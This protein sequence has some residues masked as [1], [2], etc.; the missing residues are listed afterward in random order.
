MGLTEPGPG[1][2]IR[3]HIHQ[4]ERTRRNL[5]RDSRGRWC[6]LPGQP[7]KLRRPADDRPRSRRR[8]RRRSRSR[9]RRRRSRRRR[10]G[11]SERRPK[12]RRISEGHGRFR[13]RSKE[14]L[15]AKNSSQHKEVEK[16]DQI[17]EF[18]EA[19]PDFE[20]PV[21]SPTSSNE[22]QVT[23]AIPVKQE[24]PEAMQFEGD[25]A[26]HPDE[27]HT[28]KLKEGPGRSSLSSLSKEERFLCFWHN[29][30]RTR[31]NVRRL[32]NEPDRWVC[33]DE[34]P[35][36]LEGQRKP[37]PGSA[38]QTLKQKL[39]KTGTMRTRPSKGSG[40]RRGV[41]RTTAPK[42]GRFAKGQ[43]SAPARRSEALK[44]SKTSEEW[45]QCV[46]HG[47][48]RCRDLMARNVKG[49]WVCTGDDRCKGVDK[50]L[51][52]G[53]PRSPSRGIHFEAKSTQPIRTGGNLVPLG[54]QRMKEERS[55]SRGD[56][57][58]SDTET[59]E[60]LEEESTAQ[61]MKN[62][63]P[64]SAPTL[65]MRMCAVHKK[66]RH[67]ER[68]ERCGR[69]W[70]CKSSDSCRTSGPKKPERSDESH[71]CEIHN[72]VRTVQNMEKRRDGKWICKPEC[73]CLSSRNS[74]R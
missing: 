60:L 61:L 7:C 30:Y 42:L 50:G 69:G 58:G 12:R 18:M 73:R 66:L 59:M 23:Q 74:E 19:E 43:V 64:T 32:S 11:R 38:L 71:V 39:T 41:K 31:R 55:P 3:C 34:D 1:A 16:K 44:S 5:T 24:L 67:P 2:K 68:L 62:A 29:R 35:C 21:W 36:L 45:V 52:S 13:H 9:S 4:A 25:A 15:A 48:W 14:D 28:L 33:K 49:E 6:C 70:V 37:R 53:F 51:S 47:K 40:S 57:R 20:E 17:P 22:H 26:V 56:R 72:R 63:K 27:E 8:A 46:Q 65:S 10:S 54:P